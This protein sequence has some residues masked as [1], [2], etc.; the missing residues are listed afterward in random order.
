MISIPRHTNSKDY[1]VRRHRQDSVGDDHTG[2]T[3]A[4]CVIRPLRASHDTFN[5]I[6]F[7][8][9]FVEGARLQRHDRGLML[10]LQ[11]VIF[12]LLGGKAYGRRGARH[13]SGRSGRAKM[14]WRCAVYQLRSHFVR[15]AGIAHVPSIRSI[16]EVPSVA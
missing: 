7:P 10:I 8:E 14:V 1:D 3:F 5:F 11:I 13:R 9:C 2:V 15:D 4:R 12:G 16:D 6:W